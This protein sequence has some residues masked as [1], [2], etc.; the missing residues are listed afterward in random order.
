MS[1]PLIPKRITPEAEWLNSMPEGA[2]VDSRVWKAG[3]DALK[4]AHAAEDA[5]LGFY[6]ECVHSRLE[7]EGWCRSCGKYCGRV[8]PVIPERRPSRRQIVFNWIM[9]EDLADHDGY[10]A[11]SDGVK[12]VDELL[13]ALDKDSEAELQHVKDM[14]NETHTKRRA[15]EAKVAEQAEEMLALKKM[16]DG[17]DAELVRLEAKVAEQA[18]TIAELQKKLDKPWIH[19]DHWRNPET[20]QV[21]CECCC[22]WALDA[23]RDASIIAELSRSLRDFVE[24]TEGLGAVKIAAIAALRLS[25]RGH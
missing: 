9:G 11:G 2:S 3:V 22:S 4:R 21:E 8:E 20:G 7:G 19:T 18:V 23:E 13:A 24:I 12:S 25:E 6:A 14:G 16:Y 15:A 1:K 5:L 10:W 17:T